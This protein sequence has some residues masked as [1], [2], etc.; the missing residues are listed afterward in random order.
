MNTEYRKIVDY[1][2][3]KS[4]YIQDIGLFHGKMGIVFSLYA[5]AKKY[6]DRLLEDFA[7]DLLQQIY[8]KVHTDTPTG[9]EN[10]LA[11]IGY[12][13]TLLSIL[14]LIEC[15]LNT[16]LSDIDA[17]IMERDPRRMSDFSVRTGAGGVLLYLALR[18][19]TSGTLLTFD[20]QYVAE[21]KSAAAVKMVLNPVTNIL[22][23]LNEPLFDINCYME[24]PI[25]IDGGSA[26]YILKDILS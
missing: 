14:G 12:G 4:P 10:G 20:N 16:V 25:G 3:L 21:L 1:L 17:K 6:N 13:T 5:Y 24:K 19:E 2:L 22:D 26:Y 15:D 8:N 23:I 7:W 18:Q 9:L 11:G